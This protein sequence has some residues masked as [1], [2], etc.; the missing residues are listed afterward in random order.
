MCMCVC[1]S[2]CVFVPTYTYMQL[3]STAE[4][5]SKMQEELE[6]MRPL[7]EE[8]ARDT[9]ITMEKIKASLTRLSHITANLNTARVKII[10]G[11]CTSMCVR[12][13]RHSGCRGDSCCC[14]G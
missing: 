5:V 13:G 11:H 1:A 3:L 9:V 6:T 12:V 4:D 14:A 8:A 7:L 10:T 2:V